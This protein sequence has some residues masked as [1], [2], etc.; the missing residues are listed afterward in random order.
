MVL[1]LIARVNL[2]TSDG[3]WGRNVIIFGA[4]FLNSRH[5]TNKTQNILVLG[6]A[7]FQKINDASIYAE[8]MYSPNFSVENKTL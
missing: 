6:E 2:H 7:F 8:K 1:R 5:A 4:D 3:G